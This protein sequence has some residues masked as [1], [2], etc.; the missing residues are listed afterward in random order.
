MPRAEGLDRIGGHWDRS[1]HLGQEPAIRPPE[2]QRAVGLSIDVIALLVHRA[3]VPAT[4]Q[5][6]VRQ[7]GRAALRPVADMM[8][9]AGRQPA[10]R[11]AAALVPVVERAPQRRGNCP[12]PRSTSSVRPSSSCRITTRLASHASRCDV[13]A[14]TRAPSSRTAW[15]G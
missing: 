13:P 11:K 15:P 7:R 10:A 12:G 3:V 4:E 9:L 2:R 1:G 6:E 14:E 8:P 5:R